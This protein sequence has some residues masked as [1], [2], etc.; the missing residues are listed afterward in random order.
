MQPNNSFKPSPLRGLV[1]VC[2]P[3]QRAGLTQP[4]GAYWRRTKRLPVRRPWIPD[5]RLP[6][7]SVHG[8]LAIFSA[9]RY[10][11]TG[12]WVPKKDALVTRRSLDWLPLTHLVLLLSWHLTI[13]CRRDRFAVRLN[14]A[15]SWQRSL[16][17]LCSRPCQP[18]RYARFPASAALARTLRRAPHRTLCTSAA[19]G[20]TRPTS[21]G[22]ALGHR[23]YRMFQSFASRFSV[24]NRGQLTT[25]SSRGR[26]APRLNRDVRR[27]NDVFGE[28]PTLGVGSPAGRQ[29]VPLD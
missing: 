17:S 21:S 15:V 29:L 24:V 6:I 18:R 5:A 19:A 22:L 1:A 8:P 13:R 4:L 7:P 12:H 28:R 27:L 20:L 25:S 10:V 2:G 16:S 9:F 3:R 14:S 26:F 11:L 23:I